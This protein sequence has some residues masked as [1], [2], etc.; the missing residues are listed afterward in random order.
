MSTSAAAGQG[1]GHT[2]KDFDSAMAAMRLQVLAMGGLVIDQVN[3][4]VHAWLDRDRTAAERVVTREQQVN[5]YETLIE[6]D[7]VRI[8]ALRQPVASDLRIAVAVAR[9]VTDL[10]RIGDEAKKIARLALPG[11]GHELPIPLAT[12]YRHARQMAQLCVQMLRH[13]MTALDESDQSMAA[14]VASTDMELDAEFDVALRLV[15]T[16]VMEDP[17]TLRTT[18]DTVFALKG[19]ERIGDHAKNIAEHVVY[20][21]SGSD[22]RHLRGS[23]KSDA[24]H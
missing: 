6:A 20:L 22:V 3:E 14:Q 23:M 5:A 11:T 19:L 12:V 15:M 9:A 4:A 1:E 18:I 10:E 21:A 16:C 13:S 7:I 17:R 24:Q 8:L 2:L